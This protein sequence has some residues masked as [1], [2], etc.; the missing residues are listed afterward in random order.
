MKT[1]KQELGS[2]AGRTDTI[3][4]TD[5]R[6]RPGDILSQVECGKE[7]R[8]TRNGNLI[9]VISKPENN[10]LELGAE[11]RRCGLLK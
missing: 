11:A 6:S 1:L 8:I 10:A 2:L 4:I 5:L 9:A 7:F 3:T